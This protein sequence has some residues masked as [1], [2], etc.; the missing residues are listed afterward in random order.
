MTE[1]VSDMFV[2][3]CFPASELVDVAEKGD[4]LQVERN[5]AAFLQHAWSLEKASN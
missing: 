5:M 1:H 3:A 4:Q 2:D